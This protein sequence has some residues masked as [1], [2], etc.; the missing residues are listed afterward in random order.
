MKLGALASLSAICGAIGCAPEPSSGEPSSHASDG[1]MSSATVFVF[2]TV[3]T[4]TAFCSTDTVNRAIDR[5]YRF[6][7]LFSRTIPESDIGRINASEGSPIEVDP[8]TARI[9]EQALEYSRATDGLFDITIGSVSSLW[10]FKQGIVADEGAIA[11]AVRHVDYRNVEVDGCTVTLLDPESKLDLGGIAKGYVAE[12]LAAFLSQEG[13]R[14]ACI[15]LGG[16]IRTIG[17][18]PDGTLWRIGIQNPFED[19][20]AVVSTYD[21]EDCSLV[22][23]SLTE[24]QF[25]KDGKRYWHI[26]DPR[27]GYP[28]ETDLV[29]ASIVSP[30]GVDG[31]GYTK[32]LFMMDPGDSIEFIEQLPNIEALLISATGSTFRT[33]GLSSEP[34]RETETS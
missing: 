13:C 3:A 10:D 9:I 16:T 32:A 26:L 11:E 17:T 2:D 33:S 29:S 14:S 25:V 23:S 5:C 7:S 27:T 6:E 1:E 28:V 22:T 31:E 4:I 30:S 8:D 24:R 18:K 34:F 15:D 20:G 12:D 19:A 21:L